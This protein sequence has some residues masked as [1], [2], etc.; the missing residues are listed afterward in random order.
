MCKVLIPCA[1]MCPSFLRCVST[2]NKHFPFLHSVFIC[3]LHNVP[4][5][6]NCGCAFLSVSSEKNLLA[7]AFCCCLYFTVTLKNLGEYLSVLCLTDSS[8]LVDQVKAC[9][10]M[11]S[12]VEQC[13][14]CRVADVHCCVSVFHRFSIIHLYIYL[15]FPVIFIFYTLLQSLQQE[16]VY[17]TREVFIPSEG[18]CMGR[19]RSHLFKPSPLLHT[20]VF[21]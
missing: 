20:E 12:M 19:V 14:R 9:C 21:S 1:R 15:S 11:E 4:T 3:I 6:W 16:E 5:F 10:F 2:S 18:I 8:V 17:N 7:F 13:V